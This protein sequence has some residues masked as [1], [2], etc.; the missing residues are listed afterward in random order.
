MRAGAWG[1]PAA[2]PSSTPGRWGRGALS[3]RG[4]LDNSASEGPGPGPGYYADPSIPGYVRYW[5]GRAWVPGSSRPM[6]EGG[7][8]APLPKPAFLTSMVGADPRVRAWTLPYQS[9]FAA[10]G[11]GP[12]SAPLVR[13]VAARGVDAL[14]KFLLVTGASA[15]IWLD[16]MTGVQWGAILAIALITGVLYEALPTA[17]WGRTPGKWLFAL[18]V[19]DIETLTPP[20]IRRAT[21]R[22]LMRFA[23]N[24]M[25]I[26]FLVALRPLVDYP[27]RQGWHDK[28]ART[29]VVRQ[30][31]TV[32]DGKALRT[33]LRYTLS[34]R[35]RWLFEPRVLMALVRLSGRPLPAAAAPGASVEPERSREGRRP[36]DLL[37]LSDRPETTAAV[38]SVE[39]VLE[40]VFQALGPPPE[41]LRHDKKPVVHGG[42]GNTQ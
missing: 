19:V 25:I 30:S 42:G 4:T 40:R 3:E 11:D 41:G 15:P 16:G 35:A 10:V 20:G 38:G 12:R 34:R 22:Y 13:R 14:F 39:A 23:A 26:G 9:P 8:G 37:G 28:F 21:Q 1:L 33:R 27:R 29:W 32:P 17:R 31:T 36:L 6:P 24:V 18:A 7:R 5:D 2:E